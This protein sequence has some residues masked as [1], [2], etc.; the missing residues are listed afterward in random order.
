MPFKDYEKQ[1]QNARENYYKNRERKKK[2]VMEYYF[3]HK[4]E[5]S[6]RKK[7]W[8]SKNID[9]CKLAMKK[10]NLKY[11]LT[12]KGKDVLKK[13]S[14]KWK[15]KNKEKMRAHW[16]IKN[17]LKNGQIFRPSHCELCKKKLFTHAH[18]YINYNKE[19]YLN[20]KWL[21]VICHKKQHKKYE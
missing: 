10:Y 17:A 2:Q 6:E 9:K 15:K 14:E 12:D 1:K 7:K 16:A 4:K 8:F 5:C 3:S 20:V 21:C 19:N 18:H 13:A 11:R